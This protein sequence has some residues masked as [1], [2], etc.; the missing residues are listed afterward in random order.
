MKFF[1]IFLL[2]SLLKYRIPPK[3]HNDKY[4]KEL[5][6]NGFFACFLIEIL[7]NI[8]IMVLIIGRQKIL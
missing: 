2:K 3:N 7:I 8:L 4:E 6:L 5:Y 1:T